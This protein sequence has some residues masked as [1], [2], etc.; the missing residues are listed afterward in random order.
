MPLSVSDIVPENAGVCE[1]IQTV[2]ADAPLIADDGGLES[3][4][5][6]L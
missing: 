4:R 5:N 2:D 6:W 3:H 1:D